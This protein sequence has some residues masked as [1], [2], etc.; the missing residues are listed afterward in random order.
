MVEF[1]IGDK[2]KI[3]TNEETS[4]YCHSLQEGSVGTVVGRGLGDLQGLE[5][6]DVEAPM[7]TLTGEVVTQILHSSELELVNE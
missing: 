6:Y 4:L 5:D 2:V 3:L 1:K 7:F